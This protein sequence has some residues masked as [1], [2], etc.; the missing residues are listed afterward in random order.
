MDMFFYLKGDLLSRGIDNFYLY[1]TFKNI[2]GF[3]Y[4]II[5][6]HLFFQKS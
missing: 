6:K 5:R 2:D 4:K 3:E 1:K